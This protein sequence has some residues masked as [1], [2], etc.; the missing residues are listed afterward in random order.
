MYLIHKDEYGNI[1]IATLHLFTYSHETS[2]AILEN[3]RMSGVSF[4]RIYKPMGNVI[5][6]LFHSKPYF[7]PKC[8][9]EVLEP[10]YRY[11]TYCSQILNYL[12][13]G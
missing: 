2:S 7:C 13:H 5:S 4:T 9:F 1:Q 8:V 6:N 12:V 11:T 10:N 3:T